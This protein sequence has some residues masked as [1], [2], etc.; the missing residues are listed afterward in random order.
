M[1]QEAKL[2]AKV[3]A[4]LPLQTSEAVLLICPSA[5][6][7]AEVA[8]ALAGSVAIR[9]SQ[10]L[11]PSEKG[12]SISAV[13]AHKE[14]V[15]SCWEKLHVETTRELAIFEEHTSRRTKHL[16]GVRIA[17][18]SATRMILGNLRGDAPLPKPPQ[19]GV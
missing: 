14:A 15:R 17:R 18:T 7:V 1:C 4:V 19:V 16:E 2:G 8:C 12:G 6:V 13:Q 3:L 11:W 10:W 5:E 9:S